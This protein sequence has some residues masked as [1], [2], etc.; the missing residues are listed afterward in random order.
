MSRRIL[1]LVKGYELIYRSLLLAALLLVCATAA[2]GQTARVGDGA[3]LLRFPDIHGDMI[4]FV[5]AGDI[6]T[7]P[8]AG[9]ALGAQT[10]GRQRRTWCDPRAVR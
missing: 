8:A 6:W 2:L 4:A 1:F 7:V 10:E 9:E 5:Y 3:R